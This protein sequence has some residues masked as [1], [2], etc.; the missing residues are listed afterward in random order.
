MTGGDEEG[1]QRPVLHAYRE[2]PVRRH[3]DDIETAG[4][5]EQAAER[6]IDSRRTDDLVCTCRNVF[7]Y[8]TLPTC[9]A[10]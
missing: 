7:R 8:S 9:V 2:E 10:R 3:V 5:P 6:L 1:H 4:P